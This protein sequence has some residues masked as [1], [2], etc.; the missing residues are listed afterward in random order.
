MGTGAVVYFTFSLSDTGIG[1]QPD[2]IY[3]I[4]QRF[5]QANVMT[6]QTYGR[7][8]LG[9]FISKGLTEKMAGEIGEMSAPGIGSSFVFYIKTRR[10]ETGDASLLPPRSPSSPTTPPSTSTSL[11]TKKYSASISFDAIAMS[12]WR[13]TGLK[14]STCCAAVA[15]P[16][17]ASMSY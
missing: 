13:T 8:G 4:F 6:Q 2:E 1:M 15:V 11:V 14:H 5:Q 7:S 12:K 3:K 9:L 10:V 16:P 17:H